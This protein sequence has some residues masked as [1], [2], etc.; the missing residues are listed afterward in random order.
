MKNINIA[1]VGGAGHVGMPLSYVLAKNFK[2]SIID[3][4]PNLNLLKKKKSPF[5]WLRN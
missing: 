2:V 5:F 3:N 4:S 1:V